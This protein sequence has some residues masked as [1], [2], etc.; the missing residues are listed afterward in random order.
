[1]SIK[2][3]AATNTVIAASLKIIRAYVP[4][5]V[6]VDAAY[7]RN[8]TSPQF[9][10]SCLCSRQSGHGG[11]CGRFGSSSHRADVPSLGK[12]DLSDFSNL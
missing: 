11:S 9:D 8:P 12:S 1:M 4:T 7:S 3:I 5:T 10:K 6:L 2:C